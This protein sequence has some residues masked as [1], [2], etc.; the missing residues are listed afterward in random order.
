[1]ANN[2]LQYSFAVSNLTPEEADTLEEA[3]QLATAEEDEP[4]CGG[5]SGTNWSLGGRELWVRA[6]E[7]GD[8]GAIAELLQV[9]LEK[10]NSDRVIG[11]T[12]AETCSKMA[13]GEFS[14]GG[15][16]ITK[17]EVVWFSPN[18]Q[19]SEWLE[20][21]KHGQQNLVGAAS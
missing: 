16:I 14:G 7:Y 17:D 21:R 11:F 13:I 9:W 4:D 15:V 5:L 2:Y 19:M 10:L 20:A 3:F 18:A 6:E 12:W 8:P 1:M